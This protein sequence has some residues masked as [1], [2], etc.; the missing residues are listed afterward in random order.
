MPSNHPP[1]KTEIL[2]LIGQ[3]YSNKAIARR[4]GISVRTVKFHIEAMF[5][6]LD[7]T[8]QA[9]AAA[10]GLIGTVIEL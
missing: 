5:G 7:A 1:R 4:L 3:D 9:E 10:K 8:N 6:K 2:I